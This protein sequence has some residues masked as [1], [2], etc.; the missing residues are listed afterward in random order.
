MLPRKYLHKRSAESGAFAPRHA[1]DADSCRVLLACSSSAV[2]GRG[3]ADS[4][5]SR[6]DLFWGLYTCHFGSDANN[7]VTRKP[8]HRFIATSAVCHPRVGR[9][10]LDTQ[11]HQSRRTHGNVVRATSPR[12]ATVATPQECGKGTQE[13]SG[14]GVRSVRHSGQGGLRDLLG[15]RGAHMATS[16]AEVRREVH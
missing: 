2:I 11:L 14:K 13:E 3:G 16:S 4:G 15:E 12:A 7:Q 9:S 6:S 5:E 8:L 1:P 10:F